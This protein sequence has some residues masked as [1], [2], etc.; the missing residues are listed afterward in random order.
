PLLSQKDYSEILILIDKAL[1]QTTEFQ[2]TFKIKDVEFGFIPN[3]D[4]ITAGEYRDLTLYSQDV[5]EMH[6]LMAVLF[7]P[8]KSKVANNYKI[9]E[10]NGTEKRA[11]VMKYMPLSIVNGALVFFS[12][13]AN[14]LIAYTQK[15]TAEEQARE[16]TPATTSKNGGGMRRF[17]KCARAKFGSW[18]KF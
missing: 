8:I 2:P 15:Y 5:A 6:K 9:V 13:L 4:K 3:F 11:E 18:I 14:E 16:N 10:Y 1:E 7:R 12:N 17:L